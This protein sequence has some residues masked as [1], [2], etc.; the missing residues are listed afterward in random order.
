[1]LAQVSAALACCIAAAGGAP[2]PVFDTP[3]H[4]WDDGYGHTGAKSRPFVLHQVVSGPNYFMKHDSTCYFKCIR[5]YAQQQGYGYALDTSTSGKRFKMWEKAKFIAGT[6]QL[7]EN[8][9]WLVYVDGDACIADRM[10]FL[11]TVVADA[12]ARNQGRKCS[13]IGQDS[14]HVINA[15]FLMF[16]KDGVG[17]R[18]AADWYAAMPPS[19]SSRLH[20]QFFMHVLLMKY[21]VFEL[22]MTQSDYGRPDVLKAV[23]TNGDGTTSKD[24]FNSWLARLNTTGVWPNE[25]TEKSYMQSC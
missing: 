23:D 25:N 5:R 16:K 9:D 2:A 22:G 18:F 24:E 8:D 11:E 7:L 19:T 17:D 4:Q 14:P 21:G 10:R 13:L 15:G 12:E 20:D 6:M 3:V 1:M